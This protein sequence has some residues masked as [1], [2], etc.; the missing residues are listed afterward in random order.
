M[1]DGAEQN[2][3]GEMHRRRIVM[4]DGRRYMFLYT[5]GD[6]VSAPAQEE[7]DREEPNA[8]AEATEERD[9]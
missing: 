6:E 1:M 7:P 2:E 9:V 4:A 8:D 5:F 3:G